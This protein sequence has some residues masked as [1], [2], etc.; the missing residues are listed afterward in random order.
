MRCSA[1]APRDNAVGAVRSLR[2]VLLA[3]LFAVSTL[4]R[5]EGITL[6]SATLRLTDDAYELSAKFDVSFTP[7]TLEALNKGLPL[8]FVTEFEIS[9]P[10]WYWLDETIV[11]MELP[12][13]V[14]YNALTRQYRL[15]VG[16][17]FQNFDSLQEAMKVITRINRRPVARK[18]SLE[19]GEEY[20][21]A[22]RMRLDTS[23][24]PKPFQ[25]DALTSREWNLNSDW[26]TWKV[27]P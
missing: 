21:A 22:L 18:D 1:S 12:Y 25:V 3:L 27:I 17:L 14:S 19:K 6:S 23:Q 26:H 24:L 10:R 11:R 20:T 7:A 4:V 16:P 9:R 8:Y 5:G 15:S 2:W 13:K